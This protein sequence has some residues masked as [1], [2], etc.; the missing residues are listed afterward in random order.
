LKKKR[1]ALEE[2]RT[3]THKGKLFAKNPRTYGGTLHHF[4]ELPNPKLTPLG[5]KLAGY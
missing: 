2:L 4:T 3:T 5:K 1:K